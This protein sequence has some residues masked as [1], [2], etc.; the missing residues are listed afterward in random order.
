VPFFSC[1]STLA[2]GYLYALRPLLDILV[3]EPDGDTLSGLLWQKAGFGE[4][5]IPQ[6]AFN[7]PFFFPPRVSNPYRLYCLPQRMPL[8]Q[9]LNIPTGRII[10]AFY[11]PCFSSW[12][13]AAMLGKIP[14][15]LQNY[16]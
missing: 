4:Y 2:G 5:K 7:G 13:D 11:P 3:N 1:I 10:T 6:L 8:T 12:V 16:S 15:E 9:P 14:L